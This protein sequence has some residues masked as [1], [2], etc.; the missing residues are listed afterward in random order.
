MV[1]SPD[2]LHLFEATAWLLDAEPGGLWCVS[3]WNDNGF[4]ADHAWDARRLFRTSFFPGLGWMMRRELWLELGPRWPLN[5]WDH[6]MRMPETAAGRGC[7]AP[8]LNRNKNIGE[9]GANMNRRA[10]RRFLASMAWAEQAVSGA[11]RVG[12]RV[13]EGQALAAGFTHRMPP[14]VTGGRLGRSRLPPRASLL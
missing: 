9:T 1:F 8:E 3:S 10:F 4:A 14:N 11:G 2:F 12:R 5:H 6:W 13:G 7:V